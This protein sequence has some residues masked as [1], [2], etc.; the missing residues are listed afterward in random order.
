MVNFN[1]YENASPLTKQKEQAYAD[2]IKLNTHVDIAANIGARDTKI[3]YIKS[4]PRKALNSVALNSQPYI[5]VLSI[6]K[7][8]SVS[9]SAS[10]MCTP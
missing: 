10:A 4:R 6:E 1:H 2:V 5:A 3:N 7:A 9:M 8:K